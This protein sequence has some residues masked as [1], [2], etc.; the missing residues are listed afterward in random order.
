[1]R[2]NWG[3]AFAIAT[4]LGLATTAGGLGA[5]VIPA[6]TVRHPMVNTRGA[7]VVTDAVGRAT[8]AERERLNFRGSLPPIQITGPQFVNA[9]QLV[10]LGFR[11]LTPGAGGLL[12]Q[13]RFHDA[14][15]TWHDYYVYNPQTHFVRY[16]MERLELDHAPLVPHRYRR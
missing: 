9:A 8:D 11:R 13:T 5:R 10:G 3:T 12:I 15:G 4:T 7:N 6:G 16:E 2:L 14:M 1:M